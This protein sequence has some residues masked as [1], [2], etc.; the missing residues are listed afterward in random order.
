MELEGL[1]V[2]VAGAGAGGATTALLLARGGARVTLCERVAEPRAV[3]A[4]I[5]LA[6]NGLAVLAGLGLGDELARRGRRID[7]PRICDARGRTLFAPRW[8]GVSGDPHVLVIRRSDLQDVLLGAVALEPNIDIRL[9]CEVAEATPQGEAL[10]VAELGDERRVSDLVVGADGVASRVRDGGRF[11]QRL[12]ATGISYV[13]GLT[14]MELARSEEAWTTAGI[15]GSFPVPGGAYFFTSAGAPELARALADRDLEAFA[16]VWR[17]A[18]PPSEEILAGVS[19]FDRLLVNEVARVDCARFHDGR[20]AL[21]GDAAHAMA[22]NLGQGANSA[23]VDAAVLLDEIRRARSIEEA[24]AA[25][26][27]RRVS[28]VRRVQATAG[29]LGRLAERTAPGARFLRDRVLMSFA[30]RL[31]SGARNRRLLQEPPEILLR[32]A[33]SAA[34]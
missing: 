5:A 6:P 22:P 18:Y 30:A 34:S 27:A 13:R 19:R 2:L 24:L 16:A 7:E 17:E 31:P 32:I 23:L 10:L 4:G 14:A 25:Y 28:A 15:F 3:G 20:M 8:E 12:A 29:R 26:S 33:A 9:G 21:V 1:S 11:G